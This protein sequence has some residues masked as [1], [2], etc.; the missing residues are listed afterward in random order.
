MVKRARSKR[1]TESLPGA[2]FLEKSQTPRLQD[3][4]ANR[5]ALDELRFDHRLAGIFLAL[6]DVIDPAHVLVQPAK[7]SYQNTNHQDKRSF[8]PQLD[9]HR[10]CS[11]EHMLCRPSTN[12]AARVPHRS[13][14][15][16]TTA[17]MIFSQTT[18]STTAS[19]SDLYAQAL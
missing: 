9:P 19:P 3:F 11:Y 8:R 12:L 6:T 4:G 17:G 1:R 15:S 13:G 2:L 7:Q 5:P 10:Y 18:S 14:R 16:S